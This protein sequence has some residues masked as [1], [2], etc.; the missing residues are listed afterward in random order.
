MLGA[1][2]HVIRKCNAETSLDEAKTL[3]KS[4]SNICV[5]HIR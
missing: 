3:N 5:V 4:Y 2:S 1:L